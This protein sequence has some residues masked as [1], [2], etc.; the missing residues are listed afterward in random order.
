MNNKKKITASILCF[1]LLG[2]ASCSGNADQETSNNKDEVLISLSDEQILINNEETTKAS[3][4]SISNDIIYYEEGK[5]ETYGEGE[6]SEAHSAEDASLHQVVKISEPGTYRI[7]GEL[8]YGQILIDLGENAKDDP[9]AVVSLILDNVQLTSTVSSA[10]VVLN[11]YECAADEAS[12]DVD[13]QNAGFNL[14]LAD[15]STNTLNGSHVAKIYEEGSQETLYKFDGAIESDVSMNIDGEEKDNGILNLTADREGIESEMH[16]TINGG[17]INIQSHDDA[18]NASEDGVSVITINDG[19]ITC[20]STLGSEGDGMD[21]NGWIVINGGMITAVANEQSM[22]SGVDSDNGI[23]INGGTLLATGN[24]YDEISSDSSQSFVVMNIREGVQKDLIL[25]L[26]NSNGETIAAFMTPT[27]ASVLVY[28]SSD[29]ADETYTLVQANSIEA[30]LNGY[31]YS[32][33]Q[34]LSDTSAIEYSSDAGNFG[35]GRGDMP[36]GERPEMPQDGQPPQNGRPQDNQ[37]AN[38]FDQLN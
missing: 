1:C 5:D 36:R 12:A 11:A 8:S 24:M 31:I 16:L 25:A 18:I 33:I 7:S 4:V 30:D 34:S 28:S 32:N 15:D 10:I 20:L 23:L 9:E 2:L 37:S 26:N 29:L 17:I 14:I 3:G 22:D 35:L 21:S 27:N 13:T 38:G 19:S 6:A